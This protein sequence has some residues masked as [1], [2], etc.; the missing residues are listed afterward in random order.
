MNTVPWTAFLLLG[1]LTPLLG[2][3]LAGREARVSRSGY[4]L[5]LLWGGLV[6]PCGFVLLLAG[7]GYHSP[8]IWWLYLGLYLAQT[9]ILG[10]QTARRLHD[11]G[12]SRWLGLPVLIPLVGL[13]PGLGLLLLAPAGREREPAWQVAP[14]H[15]GLTAGSL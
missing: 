7:A 11:A 15:A 4:A 5:W 1:L 12:R 14:A 13:V 3:A 10:A 2:L 8:V 6:Y 9:F